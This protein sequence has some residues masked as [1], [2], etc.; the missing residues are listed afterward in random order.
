MEDLRI[1][2]DIPEGYAIVG[3]LIPHNADLMVAE[4][5]P[6]SDF[7]IM[8]TLNKTRNDGFIGTR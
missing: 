2:K 7:I 3:V 4:R 8:K 6:I 1:Y 5:Y